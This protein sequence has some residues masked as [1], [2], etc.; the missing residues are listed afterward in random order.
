VLSAAR[1]ASAPLPLY[2]LWPGADAVEAEE[3][4]AALAVARASALARRTAS[5]AALDA[6][7]LE[8]RVRRC[9]FALVLPDGTARVPCRSAC[10]DLHATLTSR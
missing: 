7:S 8:Q 1:D 10:N 4:A 5:P 3:A 9:A 6:M 2:V